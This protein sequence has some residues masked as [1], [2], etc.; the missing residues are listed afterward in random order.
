M[1]T[2]KGKAKSGKIHK[3]LPLSEKTAARIKSL[4]L[5]KGFTS[6]EMFAFNNGFNRSQYITYEKGVDLRLSS[7]ERLCQAHGMTM[8][9]FFSEG[10]E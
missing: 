4:R 9:E 5:A 8:A 3:G 10:F 2:K 6:A 1:A 7:L